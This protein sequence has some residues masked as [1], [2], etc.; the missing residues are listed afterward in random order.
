[1]AGMGGINT[2]LWV[3]RTQSDLINRSLKFDLQVRDAVWLS[4]RACTKIPAA[5]RR[6]ADQ[7]RRN[8]LLLGLGAAATI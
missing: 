4:G 6:V 5:D 1:M 7:S 8:T 3:H 2:R